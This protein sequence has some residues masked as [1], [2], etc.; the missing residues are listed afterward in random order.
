MGYSETKART[1]TASAS[2]KPGRSLFFSIME[3]QY[4][5]KNAILRNCSEPH[6]PAVGC[7]TGVKP[8]ASALT[9]VGGVS[10]STTSVYGPRLGLR[11]AAGGAAHIIPQYLLRDG[12]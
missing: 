12:R 3:R 1:R 2:M 11:P 5:Q 8:L 10:T 6:Q 9:D 4:C 7:S